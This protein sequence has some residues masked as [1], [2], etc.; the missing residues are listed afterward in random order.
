[1]EKYEQYVDKAG[2][3]GLY[4]QLISFLVI[5]TSL[6][7]PMILLVLPMMQKAPLFSYN[8]GTE[9]IT[10]RY[11][12]CTQYY[13]KQPFQEI[14]D[15][16]ILNP[17]EII[18]WAYELKYLC[19]TKE[20]FSLVGTIFFIAS[21]C[22]NLTFSKFPDRYGRRTIFLFNNFLSLIALLQLVYLTHLGQLVFCS[23]AMGVASLN[24]ALS[25]IILNEGV[26][27]K[28]SGLVMGTANAMFPLGGIFHA[29]I[30]YFLKDW[31]Y[32]LY[33]TIIVCIGMNIL[34]V[35]Y[36]Q[37]SPKWLLA[38]KNFENFKTT[39][40]KIAEIN[41]NRIEFD[42]DEPVIRK[43]LLSANKKVV[44]ELSPED[45]YR[46][47]VYSVWDLVRFP[48]LRWIT[49][50]NLY[51]WVIT[52][53]SFFGILLN[54]EG[55]TGNIFKDAFITYIAEFVAEVG[56]GIA[57]SKFGRKYSTL[58][59][60]LLSA[61]GSLL[62]IYSKDS[63]FELVFL[64]IGV[65]GIASAFNLLYIYTPELLPTNTKSLAMSVFSTFN[66]AA[67]SIIPILLTF[68][69]DITFIISIMSIIAVFVVLGLRES[70]HFDAGDEIKEIEEEIYEE[71]P[72][73]NARKYISLFSI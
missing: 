1:M 21:I 72:L 22:S 47:Y 51:L 19:N 34:G 43:E 35:L 29:L 71:F 6:Y 11:T 56:S 30:I 39:I 49:L 73:D 27:H 62:F 65:I 20:I 41:G 59:S 13:Y 32:Y 14:H 52:G 53:F 48:S 58:V 10:D 7:S 37:E 12:F 33:F 16:I 38:N 24:L 26:D 31:R 63:Y 3:W 42:D 60:F 18:N 61:I 70:M 9:I 15:K 40:S 23:F 54:L 69:T 50:G 68:T 36:L 55:L 64:F 45:Q 66:R 2:K 46:K 17:G 25:S 5:C 4:Q 28:Y 57:A 67:G 44:V 8:N